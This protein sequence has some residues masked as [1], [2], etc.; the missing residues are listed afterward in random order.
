MV[1]HYWGDEG[2]DWEGIDA[3]AQ[4]IGEG[5]RKW[6]VDV[7]Q[8]KEKYGTVRV[9]C[10]LGLQNLHQLTHPGYCY[11]QWPKWAWKAQFLWP[12]RALVRIL[13]L[14]VLP[15][16]IWLYKRYYREA[17]RRWPHLKKEI[18]CCADFDELLV[19]I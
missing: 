10:G 12:A 19:G 1:M 13:N 14:F 15:L 16:H 6:R 4:Y 5:L 7:R 11:N 18:L 17:V 2:V 3:A 8:W 9:Y